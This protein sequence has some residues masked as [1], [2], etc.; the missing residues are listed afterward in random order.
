MDPGP[1]LVPKPIVYAVGMNDPGLTELLVELGAEVVKPYDGPSMYKGWVKPGSTLIQCV[2]NRK[3]RF[4]GTM[5]ADRLTTI[6]TIL[7]KAVHDQMLKAGEVEK[8]N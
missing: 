4:V 6:E 7:H 1:P 3:G 8:E 5:L 2:Q